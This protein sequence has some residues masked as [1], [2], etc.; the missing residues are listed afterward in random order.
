MFGPAGHAYVYFTYGMH[1]CF[2]VVTGRDGRGEAVLVRALEPLSGLSHMARRRKITAPGAADTWIERAADEPATRR[3]LVSLTSGPAKLTQA[4]GLHGEIYGAALLN[5]RSPVQLHARQMRVPA[6]TIV[7]SP[8]IG[9]RKA[10]QKRWRFH[11]AANPYV[12][13]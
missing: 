8:R 7:S 6:R 11:I 4:M 13:R 3:A 10:T 5:R 2:N 12:S 1:W 9:I